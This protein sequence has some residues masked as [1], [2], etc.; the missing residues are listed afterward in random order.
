MSL[1]RRAQFKLE[2]RSNRTS[3]LRKCLWPT[4]SYFFAFLSFPERM[5]DHFSSARPEEKWSEKKKTPKSK[6]TLEVKL[7]FEVLERDL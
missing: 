1:R 7:R 5:F 2:K 3:P 4:V 6:P